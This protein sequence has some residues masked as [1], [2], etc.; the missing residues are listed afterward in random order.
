MQQLDRF[1][2]VKDYL[3]GKTA[4]RELDVM[5]LQEQLAQGGGGSFDPN[6]QKLAAYSNDPITSMANLDK[7]R[8]KALQDDAY[9]SSEYVKAGKPE[10]AMQILENRLEH[11]GE[12]DSQHTMDAI[13]T[14]EQG[15]QTG[16]FGEFLQ[17]AEI[18]MSM[19]QSKL[20]R[21]KKG[22]GIGQVSPKDFTVE[23]MSAY[24]QSGKIEDL[25]RYSP[26]IQTIAGVPHQ[27]NSATQKWEPII[28]AEKPGL[29]VQAK[30]IATLEA[31]KQSRTDFAASK[32][33]WR[34]GMPKFRS[35][36]SSARS[37]HD[38]LTATASQ[39]KKNI[40]SL[41]TKY[42]ASLSGIPGSEARVLKN[43]LDTLK[44]HSAFSTL[45]DLKASGGTLGAI[46][47]AELVLL[48]A[49][50][51]SLD[52]G[53]DGAELVRVIDQIINS[54][55]SSIGRLETEFSKTNDMYSG[56]FDDFEISNK[57]SLSDE[58]LIKKYG[59]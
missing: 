27:V 9:Q 7:N 21:N 22:G 3:A 42:G 34:T 43:Q 59:G 57:K 12:G 15:M 17:G 47:E 2:P 10:I 23:S 56:T 49:K 6:A 16:D 25:V 8:F 39:I 14:L 19:D 11:I 52:Q 36:I 46:S 48:M 45:T 31:D 40:S 53:G 24:E 1:N 51:G 4:K 13:K 33:Q 55:M 58:D 30:A 32:M 35:K 37:S 41:T 54:N 5:Q 20:K 29:S 18:Y 38:I 50:L 28:D 26:K 44:A